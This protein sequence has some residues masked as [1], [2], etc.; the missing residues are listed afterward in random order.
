M[1]F[2]RPLLLAPGS[3]RGDGRKFINKRMRQKFSASN[4]GA[5]GLWMKV[6]GC[7]IGRLMAFKPSRRAEPRANKSV[8]GR[9]ACTTGKEVE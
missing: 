2:K 8:T 3:A 4:D 1:A 6:E 7:A 5:F 9:N